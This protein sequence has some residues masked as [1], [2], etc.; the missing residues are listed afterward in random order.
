MVQLSRASYAG[1]APGNGG[2][3]PATACSFTSDVL[4][5]R[6]HRGAARFTSHNNCFDAHS[7]DKQTANLEANAV[8][9]LDR[10]EYLFSSNLVDQ[11]V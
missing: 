6:E 5:R 1:R 8:A 9:D 7:A 3:Q 10:F 11:L 4:I 2:L